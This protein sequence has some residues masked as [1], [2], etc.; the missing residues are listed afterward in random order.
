M[1]I[2]FGRVNAAL[3]ID[4]G[5]KSMAVLVGAFLLL[6]AWGIW[7]FRARITR[8]EISDAARLEVNG[9]AYPLQA[10]I[11]GELVA[12]HLNLG[13]EVQAGE[14]LLEL[15]SEEQLL[16]LGEQRTKLASLAPQIAAL[17][18]QMKEDSAG[19]SDD[20]RVLGF[21]RQAAA[22]QYRQAA[23]E[24]KLAAADA[25]RASRL[26]ADGIVSDADAQKAATEAAS[27][28]AA[29]G[30]L[31][32]AME[33]LEPETALRN[34]D[35]DVRLKQIGVDI[36]KLVA[37]ETNTTAAIFRLQEDVERRRI[38]AP[39]AGRLGECA[40]LRPG[41]HISEGQQLGLILPGGRLQV[42]AE[43]TPSAALGR[44]HPGQRAALRLDG[45]PWAQYGVVPARVSHV[46]GDIRDGKVRVELAVLPQAHSR[47]P[48]QHGL[49]GTVEI[50]V[51]QLSPAALV[52]RSAGQALGVN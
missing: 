12:S 37:E 9:A 44:V 32:L 45:F 8:Y 6:G 43:F 21:S 23:V 4:H 15:D 25:E 3:R 7:A 26:H 50:E 13:R 5:L 49:P 14:I 40:V 28:G 33:R 29:A 51:E 11:S 27:R 30:A 36:A 38:R 46:A 39:I 34:R 1:A 17:R 48:F 10:N 42:V 24:A 16:S 35:R 31:K 2:T 52:L 22:E 41:A 47:I 18:A 20:Q 19:H